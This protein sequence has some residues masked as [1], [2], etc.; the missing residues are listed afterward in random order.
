MKMPL[1]IFN[2]S[3]LLLLVASGCSR[4]W[5]NAVTPSNEQAKIWPDYANLAIPYNIAPLNCEIKNSGEAFLFKLSSFDGKQSYTGTG[6]TVTFPLKTWRS[7]VEA[8]RGKHLTLDIVVQRNGEWFKLLTTTN[9]VAHDPIDSALVYRLIPPS[10]ERFQ[11][12]QICQRDLTSFNERTLFSNQQ[13]SQEQCINCHTFKNYDGRNFAFHTRLYKGGT[14]IFRDGK[15]PLKTDLKD[16]NLYSGGAYP[17]WHPVD[18]NLFAFSVNKTRQTFLMTH[19]NKI[20]VLDSQSGLILYD[21]NKNEVSPIHLADNQFATFPAWSPD[22][23]TLY[24]TMAEMNNLPPVSDE[25]NRLNEIALQ[26]TNMFY[27]LVCRSFDKETKTFGVPRLLINA[28]ESHASISF[29]SVSP[30]GTYLMM[31]VLRCANFPVWHKESDLWL[32]NIKTQESRALTELNSPEADSYHAWGSNSRWFVFGS[33]REDGIHTRPYLA[34][35]NP[36]TGKA[37]KPF[38]VPQKYPHFYEET[39]LSYN[40]PELLSIPVPYSAEAIRQ[41]VLQPAV[42]ATFK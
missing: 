19:N 10:Y 34:Y 11:T 38:I 4:D 41:A 13:V 31:T 26:S 12:L 15:A 8:S 20:E 1:L 18:D 9:A 42:K 25:T 39:F 30:D 24:Y 5:P 23:K 6:K 27:H 35:F 33:R 40:R 37:G 14:V 22:G 32:Y 16:D 3:L 36:T 17:A 2:F 7:I 29:P 21:A 28:K